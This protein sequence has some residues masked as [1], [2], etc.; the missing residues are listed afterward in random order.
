M[1]VEEE[2][3][4]TATPQEI[5]AQVALD[6]VEEA[7][8]VLDGDSEETEGTEETAQ[9]WTSQIYRFSLLFTFAAD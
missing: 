4:Y 1:L 9:V 5:Q 3:E 7:Q 8:I 6:T 2:P